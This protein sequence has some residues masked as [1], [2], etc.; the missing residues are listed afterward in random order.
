[1]NL[2]IVERTEAGYSVTFRIE[3][4]DKRPIATEIVIARVSKLVGSIIKDVKKINEIDLRKEHSKNKDR[5]AKRL[6][7]LFNKL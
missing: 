7:K 6:Q 4:P 3:I 5:V 2:S 1:M